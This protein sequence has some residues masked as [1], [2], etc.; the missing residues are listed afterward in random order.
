VSGVQ[1]FARHSSM[2]FRDGLFKQN[3]HKHI[4]M[5]RLV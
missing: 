3:A 4:V 1:R 5:E 2:S